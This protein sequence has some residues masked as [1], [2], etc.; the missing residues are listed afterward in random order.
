MFSTLEALS[1]F[2]V[3]LRLC[4]SF[5]PPLRHVPSPDVPWPDRALRTLSDGPDRALRTLSDAFETS[6]VERQALVDLYY[7]TNG[8]GWTESENWLEDDPCV[9][10]WY[11]VAC[12][13]HGG[14]AIISLGDNNMTGTLEE[15]IGDLFAL[16]LLQL[17]FGKIGGSIPPS[18]GNLKTP[19]VS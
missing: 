6:D 11:G 4:G 17:Q 9:N 1:T 12:D 3:L 16:Q 2:L 18:I 19:R 15:S 10:Q 13:E 7:S 8:E 5:I 14:V